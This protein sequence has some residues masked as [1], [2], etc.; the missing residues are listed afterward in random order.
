MI[1]VKK[2]SARGFAVLTLAG[3]EGVL[4]L[5]GQDKGCDIAG[6]A[7]VAYELAMKNTKYWFGELLSKD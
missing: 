5:M 4:T 7:R 1:C 3:E 6:E 2:Q